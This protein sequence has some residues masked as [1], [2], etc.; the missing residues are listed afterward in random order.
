MPETMKEYMKRKM[1]GEAPVTAEELEALVLAIQADQ[2]AYQAAVASSI[3][4]LLESLRAVAMENADRANT[5]EFFHHPRLDEN[6][7]A[8]AN[9]LK[10]QGAAYAAAATELDTQKDKALADLKEKMK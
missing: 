4:T 5:K 8:F 6:W 2:I 3:A 7:V 10:E 9:T 1:V